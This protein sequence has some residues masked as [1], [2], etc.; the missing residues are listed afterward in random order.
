MISVVII[1]VGRMGIRHAIG[2]LDA[3][4]VKD[5]LLVDISETALQN[6]ETQFKTHPK[7]RLLSFKLS[8]QLDG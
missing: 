2:A 4:N 8:N 3:K 7:F 5:I 6:A 1:G